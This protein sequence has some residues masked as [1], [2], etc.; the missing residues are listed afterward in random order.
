[1]KYTFRMHD[2]AELFD[3]HSDPQEMRNL[4]LEESF[5]SR[6]AEMKDA[7]FAWHRPTELDL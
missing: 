7:L 2:Q 4:A 1:M 6:V 3:L 5:Q